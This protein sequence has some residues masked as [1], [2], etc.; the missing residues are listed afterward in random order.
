MKSQESSLRIAMAGLGTAA[1][2][3]LPVLS[4]TPR[5]ELVAVADV[6]SEALDAA[7]ERFPGVK[8]YDDVEELVKSQNV[9]AIWIATPNQ[10][11]ARHAIAAA[12]NGK[13]IIGEKPMALSIDECTAMVEAIDSAKVKYIQGHSKLHETAIREMGILVQSGELGEVVQIISFNSND[14]LRRPRLESE[15]DTS[16]GGGVVYRQGPH[17]IDIVRFLGGGQVARVSGHVGRHATWCDADGDYSALFEFSNGASATL[18]LNG[19][20][21]FDATELTW[22]I[23]EGGKIKEPASTRTPAAIPSGSVSP[24]EK[25]AWADSTRQDIE[26]GAAQPF[27]GLTVVICERGAVRQSP[28][29]LFVYRDGASKEIQL[30]KSLGRR[31]ELYELIR[32][33]EEDY[34]PFPGAHWGRATVEACL[35]ILE[36]SK[37]GHPVALNLQ[38]AVPQ[39][40][41]LHTDTS[42]SQQ[43]QLQS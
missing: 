9:D 5:V 40:V 41:R 20:G 6:R 1:R 14:W 32:C 3:I 35:A 2:Q 21:D 34:D 26:R 13:H 24:A 25:Y 36:S 27:F 19:Y 11:H 10:Y 16:S 42:D 12:T 8:A 43:M 18:A 37:L 17:Q 23:G 33:I 7:C 22:H 38:A 31:A 39:Q 29:G 4:N 15:L 28:S 30:R